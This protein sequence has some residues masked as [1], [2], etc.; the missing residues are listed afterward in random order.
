[1]GFRLSRASLFPG[2]RLNINGGGISTTV[3]LR[4][5]FERSTVRF[6]GPRPAG[7]GP[8]TA[9][10]LD[11]EDEAAVATAEAATSV[12][13]F[14]LQNVLDKALRKRAE[15][16]VTLVRAGRR[17]R[18]ARFAL[19]AAQLFLLRLVFRRGLTAIARKAFE[20]RKTCERL[21]GDLAACVVDVDFGLGAKAVEKFDGLVDA[22][23]ALARSDGVWDITA[24]EASERRPRP[25][26]KMPRT[27]VVFATEGL[28]IVRSDAR[29]LRLPSAQGPT[30]IVYPTVAILWRGADDFTLF[31]ARDIRLAI[32]ALSFC[33]D[34]VVPDDTELSGHTWL[35]ANRDGTRDRSAGRNRQIPILRYGSVAL[36]SAV[37]GDTNYLVSSYARTSDFRNA[38]YEFRS[39][40]RNAQDTAPW[41]MPDSVTAEDFTPPEAFLP[42]PSPPSFFT[43]WFVIGLCALALGAAI[44]RQI[45]LPAPAAPASTVASLPQS[46]PA[47]RRDVVLVMA[48]TA[49]IR[50]APNETSAILAHAR[51]GDIFQAYE[52]RGG[53]LQIGGEQPLGWVRASEVTLPGP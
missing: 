37:G 2:V 13:L 22:F 40:L 19:S 52:R 44:V 10:L 31:D 20:A 7:R 46:A 26:A 24:A 16:R 9:L 42:P 23:A 32:S 48:D 12:G 27:P 14:A 25:G 4:E 53:W 47:A 43:D 35:V 38:W 30:L 36:R 18:R 41:H 5:P 45:P 28:D 1:M 51:L 33:E 34:G 11:I 49:A 29:A 8:A 50:T 15:L 21:N 39:A 17:E 3:G 6:A